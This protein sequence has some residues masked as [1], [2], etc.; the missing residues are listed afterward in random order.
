MSP[1][2]PRFRRVAC[3]V[4]ILSLGLFLPWT[5]A[6]KP[7]DEQVVQQIVLIRHGIRSPTKAPDTLNVFSA[8]A[9]PEWSVAPGQLTPHGAQLMR[10]L[11]SWH[12]HDLAE[13][14]ISP[15]GCNGALKLIA[16]STQRNRDSAVAMLP[17][18]LP[19]CHASYYAFT[20]DHTDPLFKGSAGSDDEAT[21]STSVPAPPMPALI[22]LQQVLLGCHDEACLAKAR[23]DGKKLLLGESPASALKSAG[24]LS[25]NLM[26][27]YVQ[28]MPADQTGWGRI[29]V[30][31][32]GRVITLHNAQFALAKKNPAAASGHGGNMLVHIAATFATAAGQTGNVKPLVPATTKALILLGHDTDLAAQA[33]LL[34][35]NWHSDSQPDDYP[36]GGALIYQL[37]RVRGAYVVRLRVAMPSLSAL[38]AADVGSAGAMH[39]SPVRIEGCGHA[40]DCPLATFQRLVSAAVDPTKVVEST[41]D[42]PLV[43][44]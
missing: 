18:L 34:G 42:E 6:A 39:V 8:D 40:L 13:V 9:W 16:D 22:E 41:G 43:R 15:D 32:V 31:G 30:A 11:G 4:A 26:L 29:D 38:R 3:T 17:T 5:A 24:T 44:Q 37:M 2:R 12:R 20:P 25:E 21:P 7:S 1:K 33:G 14:G 19:G 27:E 35:L 36:P 23:A 28:G 10:A